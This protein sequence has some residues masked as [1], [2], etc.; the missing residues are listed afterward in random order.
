MNLTVCVVGGGRSA[1]HDVSIASARALTSALRQRGHRV[2]ELTVDREGRWHGEDGPLAETAA[3]SLA[4]AVTLIGACD[5]LFP[6]V[7]GSGGEDGTLA[8]LA[9]L[10][11]IPVVGS[12]LGPSAAAM[13]KAVT[14]TLA[15][16]AG[17]RV[18]PGRVVSRRELSEITF[19]GPVV[20]KPVDAGSSHGVRLV[21]HADELG[22][23]VAAAAAHS[24]RVILE[25]PVRGRE[26]DVA[27]IAGA[28]GTR[29]AGPALEIHAEGLFDTR[30]K[31]DGSARFTV[32]AE[33]TPSERSA[34]AS[35][36]TTVFD[37]LGCAGVARID[38]FLTDD[39]PV[40]NEVNTIPGLSP[41][42]QVPLMFEAIGIDFAEL[43]ER[44][45]LAALGAR[46]RSRPEQAA[47]PLVRE[48]TGRV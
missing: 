19:D 44:L 47:P 9:G 4:T 41:H 23:A 10:I 15:A 32:P 8:A 24:E 17:V 42:S 35:A 16:A 13:D 31:Y 37:A 6:A 20:V 1:E 27:V 30:T 22:A 39:G 18:A 11:G 12:A 25:A 45:V 7:H 40:L 5:A 34:L 43:A 46:R 3:L 36:A 48:R 2:L 21:E 28:D 33:L 29:W 26:I 14:K 38:F